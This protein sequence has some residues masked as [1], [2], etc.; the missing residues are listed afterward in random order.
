MMSKNKTVVYCTF[1]I[2]GQHNWPNCPFE[3][4][5]Y[6]RDPHRHVFWY[7]AYLTVN[8]DDRD[9]EFIMLKHEMIDYIKT[10][11]MNDELKMCAFGHQSC[12]MLA[13]ELVQQFKLDQCDVSEDNENGAVVYNTTGTY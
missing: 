6:L 11:Y 8:H 10:K 2:E 12:E 1:Q 3:E 5:K 13:E 9:Q 7:K 4:V